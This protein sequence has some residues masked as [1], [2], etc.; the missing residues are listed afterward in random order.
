MPPVHLEERQVDG[1]VPPERE[2]DAVDAEIEL[3]E[4][5]QERGRM[6]E[7]VHGVLRVVPAREAHPIVAI[8]AVHVPVGAHGLSGLR[9]RNEADDR[10]V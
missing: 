8:D 2:L 10:D 5:G 4:V 9:E 3:G 7:R 1:S 6:A